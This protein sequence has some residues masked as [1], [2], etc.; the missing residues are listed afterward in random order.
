[1][2]FCGLNSRATSAP[3]L[4]RTAKQ[5][6]KRLR[7][8]SRVLVSADKLASRVERTIDHA[9]VERTLADLRRRRKVVRVKIAASTPG[10]MSERDR[11]L[12]QEQHNIERQISATAH[13]LVPMREAHG[14]RVE[15]A[16]KPENEA[17]AAAALAALAEAEIAIGRLNELRAELRLVGRAAP[18]LSTKPLL[19][20]KL[21]IEHAVRKSEGA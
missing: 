19:M 9:A 13:E 10:V 11:Q 1:M 18:T 2:T 4:S 6:P 5:S 15:A 8:S 21:Q 12:F 7:A 17:A 14:K 20:M 16:L 3:N